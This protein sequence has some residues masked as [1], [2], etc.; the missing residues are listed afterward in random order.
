MDGV[1]GRFDRLPF[2]FAHLRPADSPLYDASY[3]HPDFKKFWTSQN[4]Q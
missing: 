2:L 4:R 3:Y 1:M